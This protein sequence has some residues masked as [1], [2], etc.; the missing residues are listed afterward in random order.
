MIRALAPVLLL[1]GCAAQPAAESSRA[2]VQPDPPSLARLHSLLSAPGGL[3]APA[4]AVDYYNGDEVPEDSLSRDVKIVELSEEDGFEGYARTRIAGILDGMKWDEEQ[5]TGEIFFLFN[6]P[7]TEWVLQSS[8]EV[9]NV[10]LAMVPDTAPEG[11]SETTKAAVT[12]ILEEGASYY[13]FRSTDTSAEMI[14][15]ELFLVKPYVNDAESRALEI[16]LGCC[17]GD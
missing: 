16:E 9:A 5:D 13:H 8:G 14:A 11:A 4:W 3:N 17:G 15:T 12:A 7:D 6:Y 1:V 10:L 2:R